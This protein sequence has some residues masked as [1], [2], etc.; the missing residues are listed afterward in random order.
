MPLAYAE[1]EPAPV[2]TPAEPRAASESTVRTPS[3]EAEVEE[4]LEDFII[5]DE[6]AP[7]AEP[8]P[9]LQAAPTDASLED[10]MQKLLAELTRKK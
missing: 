7:V 3:F 1:L 8:A 2:R 10:E 6:P 4:N 9:S 5:A